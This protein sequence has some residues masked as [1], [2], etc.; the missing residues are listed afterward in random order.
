MLGHRLGLI[1][2]G[3]FFVPQVNLPGSMATFA[4]PAGVPVAVAT[5]ARSNDPGL[6]LNNMA[7]VI[8]S[9]KRSS[10]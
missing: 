10:A 7:D 3:N 8:D 2:S 9:L 4:I 6:P 1:S 5:P